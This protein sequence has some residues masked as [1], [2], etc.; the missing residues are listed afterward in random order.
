MK[1]KTFI[2]ALGLMLMSFVISGCY[3]Q[4]ARQTQDDEGVAQEAVHEENGD[5][6]E[7]AEND[8][9][10]VRDQQS[11]YDVTNIYV[12]DYYRP[13]YWDPWDP[14]YYS[15]YYR[16]H[17]RNRFYVSVGW[18]AYYD[19]WDWC[20]TRWSG[21]WDP[22]YRDRYYWWGPTAVYNPGWYYPDYSPIYD[23]PQPSKKRDF[24][25]RGARGSDDDGTVADRRGSLSKPIAD[26]SSISKPGETV[27]DRGADGSYRRQRRTEVDTR[28]RATPASDE[29]ATDRRRVSRRATDSDRTTDAA[30]PA[31]GD[32]RTYTAPATSKNPTSVSKP[33]SPERREAVK[34]NDGRRSSS[35]S[36][37]SK[38]GSTTRKVAPKRESS[39]SG[40]SSSPSWNRGGSSGSSGSAARGSSSSGSS[41]SGSS[42]SGSK[43]SGSSDRRGKN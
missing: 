16:H 6:E 23:P 13:Y 26:R 1:S 3:T 11:E 9:E 15:W 42:S 8:T 12:Y 10:Y 2:L 33:K 14:W 38:E 21:Y 19:Y 32:D 25:R 37:T 24:G 40:S 17:P 36:K 39:N 18:G 7:Y 5:M 29:R 4:L 41:S 31:R 30:T 34:R 35:G 43:S 22:W 20:G 27:F 28:D